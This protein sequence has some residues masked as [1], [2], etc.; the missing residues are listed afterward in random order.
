MFLKRPTKMIIPSSTGEDKH[1]MPLLVPSWRVV[2]HCCSTQCW[3]ICCHLCCPWLCWWQCILW[4]HCGRGGK[5]M[6]VLYYCTF[7][8]SVQI[9]LGSTPWDT[10]YVIYGYQTTLS[11]YFTGVMLLFLPAYSFDFNPIE[12]S[13]PVF[14]FMSEFPSGQ[15][16]PIVP[17]SVQSCLCPCMLSVYHD[18]WPSL[19]QIAEL[20]LNTKGME[21]IQWGFLSSMCAPVACHGICVAGPTTQFEWPWLKCSCE[22]CWEHPQASI[23][24]ELM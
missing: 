13:P 4:F 18:M 15:P 21:C 10:R 24:R 6:W 20:V 5:I 1:H 19:F 12:E 9:P 23:Q 7:W 2:Q 16:T 8:Y 22:C 14:S 17:Y 3:R 11:N